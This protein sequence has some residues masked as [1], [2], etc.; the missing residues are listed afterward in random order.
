[1]VGK[2]NADYLA[3]PH[4]WPGQVRS[5]FAINNPVSRAKM[6]LRNSVD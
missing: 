6:P 1:M 3:L 5:V 4:N 2:K